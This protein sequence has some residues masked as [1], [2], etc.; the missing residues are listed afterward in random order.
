MKVILHGTS[1][2]DGLDAKALS[3]ALDM[4]DGDSKPGDMVGLSFTDGTYYSVRR[5]KTS[6]SV[7]KN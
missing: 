5:N 2:K 1:L 4:L 7:W 3:A 6:V